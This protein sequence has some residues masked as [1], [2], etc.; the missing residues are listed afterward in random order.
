VNMPDVPDSIA[1]S[2][3]REFVASLGID[4][5]Y[6]REFS[7]GMSGEH[8]EVVALNADGKPYVDGLSDNIAVHTI[9]I[10]LDRDV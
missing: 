2:K 5:K 8:V 9:A 7:C 3:V 4:P 1:L 10:P 6:L